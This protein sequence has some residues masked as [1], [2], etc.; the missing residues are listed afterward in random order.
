[1]GPAITEDSILGPIISRQPD[2]FGR[3]IARSYLGK[4]GIV[5]LS[6]DAYA[7]LDRATEILYRQPEVRAAVSRDAVLSCIFAWICDTK[8]RGPGLS[9]IEHVNSELP[10]LVQ[11]VEVVVPLY[12]LH[13]Q[14]PLKCGR[15]TIADITSSEVDSWIAV[16]GPQTEVSAESQEYFTRF[17]KQ[18]QGRAAARLTITAEKRHA[19]SRAL[20]AAELA[21]AV[22]RLVSRG[23]Y[24]PEVPSPI[25]LL[26]SQVVNSQHFITN[27]PGVSFSPSESVH[28]ADESRPEVFSRDFIAT[29]IPAIIGH[30]I[31]LL[32]KDQHSDFEKAALRSVII[33]SRATRQRNISEKLIHAFA[34]LESLLLKS[35]SEPISAAVGDRLAFAIGRSADERI[36]VAANMRAVYAMRS[37]Y[38]H[39]ALETSPQST[40][41]ELLEKFLRNLSHFFVNLRAPLAQF[42][43]KIEFLDALDRR[44]YA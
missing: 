38:V 34:A 44:K 26:G 37:R 25:A 9:L 31:A 29:S 33:Y 3:E 5:S 12:G 42:K 43:S 1:M 16:W 21:V 35:E 40:D 15:V 4:D 41:L 18:Y 22:L 13:V 8:I 19:E 23:A 10:K 32:D 27:V 24:V 7:Q 11:P 39:H 36:A 14:S 20:E 30:W 2:R 28:H 17:R 6:G